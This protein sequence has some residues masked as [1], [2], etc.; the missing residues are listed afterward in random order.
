MFP[1][2]I[3]IC[4]L[5]FIILKKQFEYGG[6]GL[7][8][9][10]ADPRNLINKNFYRMLKD[11]V[12]FY[13]TFQNNKP[14]QSISIRQYLD[15]HHYQKNLSNFI[16]VLLFPAFGLRLIKIPWINLYQVLL[17]F[18]KIIS[19]LILLIGPNGKR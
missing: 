17:V 9:L 4:L 7:R 3:V 1:L 6:G 10:F 16:S 11:I 14:D 5:V 13:K 2:Q 8:A 12:K 18:F 15:R 19:Y